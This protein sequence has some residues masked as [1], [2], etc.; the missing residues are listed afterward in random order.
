MGEMTP[1]EKW[2]KKY[3]KQA[4][5][6]A[7]RAGHK[8]YSLHRIKFLINAR[9][10]KVKRKLRILSHYGG[11]KVDCRI[12]GHKNPIT[13]DLDHIE[14]ETKS[15]LR[16]QRLYRWLEKNNYPKGFQVLCRNCNYE[17]FYKHMKS[18]QET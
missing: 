8:H 6:T 7:S 15:P 17:K 13:L 12:C 18:K 4:K 16:S 10:E 3:P 5:L 9:D 14:E 11:G 2:I 1:K